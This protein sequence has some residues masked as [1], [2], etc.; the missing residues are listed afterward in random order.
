MVSV[1]LNS[2]LSLRQ[3]R[4]SAS[5]FNLQGRLFPLRKVVDRHIK[6]DPIY[7]KYYL[8]LTSLRKI[9]LRSFCPRSHVVTAA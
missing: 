1:R 9:G 6:V 7:Y 5:T 2:I 8:K 4:R 3:L